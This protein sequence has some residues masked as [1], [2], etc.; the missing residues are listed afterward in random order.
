MEL[1]LKIISFPERSVLAH[2]TFVFEKK[3]RPLKV[4]T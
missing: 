1:L 4:K 2:P 3:D